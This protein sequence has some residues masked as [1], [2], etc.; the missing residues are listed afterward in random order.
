[1]IRALF[2]ATWLVLT[3]SFV[4]AQERTCT[5]KPECWPGGSAMHT[6]LIL[7]QERRQKEK[8]LTRKHNELLK[9]VGPPQ[10]DG[11]HTD[12]SLLDALK[13]QQVAW[14]KYRSEE[15]TLIGSL[16]GA[17]GTWPSAYASRC[18]LNHTEQRL[19]RVLSA[20]RCVK[21]IPSNNQIIQQNDCL[22][23]LAP[24]TNK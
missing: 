10:S 17:G 24:L 8:L 21:R 4:W 2:I 11:L 22:Q 19:S 1:M 7:N 12:L 9:I 6:G 18:E 16:T 14:L 3:P 20:L 5:D 13:N 15:C 23:Q